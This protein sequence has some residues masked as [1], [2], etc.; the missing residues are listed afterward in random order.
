MAEQ[1]GM[2]FLSILIDSL[3]W[4]AIGLVTFILGGL[5]QA[6]RRSI[7]NEF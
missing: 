2:P 4:L 1:N 6:R 5:L 3:D 7:A